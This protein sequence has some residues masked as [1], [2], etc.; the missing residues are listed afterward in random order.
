[1]LQHASRVIRARVIH[2]AQIAC[3]PSLVVDTLPATVVR[4]ALAE[5]L[6]PP[7][8]WA[9]AENAPTVTS[10]PNALR[11]ERVRSGC[12]ASTALLDPLRQGGYPHGLGFTGFF[13]QGGRGSLGQPYL[14]YRGTQAK[15]E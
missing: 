1:M 11:G 4:L 12:A 5:P 14:A 3:I 15:H 9:S 6:R 2:R 8:A 13:P 7:F 10:L